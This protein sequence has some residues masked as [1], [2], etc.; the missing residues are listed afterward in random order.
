M[1]IPAQPA[2]KRPKLI[3]VIFLFYLLSAGYTVLSLVVVLSGLIPLNEAQAAYFHN[4]S[5]LAIAVSL[6]TALLNIAGAIAIFRLRKIA[7]LLFIAALAISL[8]QT[9][10][11][12]FTTNFAA[13]LGG[14]GA[15]GALI[16]FGIAIA[17]CVYAWRLR[18]RGVLT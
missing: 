10:A 14:P 5:A 11:Q 12:I 3:W 6:V 1:D 2:V 9:I 4:L 7:P 16:G 18:M 17:V 15:I 8:A 13:A